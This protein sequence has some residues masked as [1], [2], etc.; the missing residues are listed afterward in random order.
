MGETTRLELLV[1]HLVIIANVNQE[2]SQLKLSFLDI[3][4]PSIY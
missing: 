4:L 1:C 3:V 2:K